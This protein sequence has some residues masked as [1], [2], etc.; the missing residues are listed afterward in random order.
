MQTL[1]IF[2]PFQKT[3]KCHLKHSMKKFSYNKSKYILTKHPQNCDFFL[4]SEKII[5]NTNHNQNLKKTL[6][7][8]SSSKCISTSISG[9]TSLSPT[10]TFLESGIIPLAIMLRS[11]SPSIFSTA[12]LASSSCGVVSFL[13]HILILGSLWFSIFWIRIVRLNYECRVHYCLL[14]WI[15]CCLLWHYL[16]RNCC[17]FLKCSLNCSIVWSPPTYL[18]GPFCSGQPFRCFDLFDLK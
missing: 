14:L 3:N 17:P 7:I 15:R 6:T 2:T 12:F 11:A 10:S 9:F 1:Y 18:S 16:Q 4:T 8:Q 5:K 13:Y